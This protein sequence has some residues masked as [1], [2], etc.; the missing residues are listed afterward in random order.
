MEFFLNSQTF[1][2]LFFTPY[3]CAPAQRA[4]LSN[5]NKIFVQSFVFGDETGIFIDEFHFLLFVVLS[6]FAISDL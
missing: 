3:L 5:I 1:W 2:L 6:R 4:N